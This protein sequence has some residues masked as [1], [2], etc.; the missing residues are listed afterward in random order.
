THAILSEA[1]KLAIAE[2]GDIDGWDIGP[3][4]DSPQS[5]QKLYSILKPY[6]KLS[7]D[8][9]QKGCFS[10]KQYK[11]LNGKTIYAWQ[12]ATHTQYAKA[13]LLEGTSL[14]FW[15]LGSCSANTGSCGVI[16]VDINGDSPPNQAGLDFFRFNIRINGILPATSATEVNKYGKEICVYNNS[17]NLNGATCTKWVL[18]KGNLDYLRRDVSQEMSKL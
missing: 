3:V 15:S 14:A 13:R 8:C 2:N 11:A 12:P 17:S 18:T 9:G 1:F 4:E 10:S 7:E 16:F 6:L 5:S